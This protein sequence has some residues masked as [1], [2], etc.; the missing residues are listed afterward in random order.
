M[1]TAWC[2]AAGHHAESSMAMGFCFF[3]SAAVAARAAQ[4]CGAQRVLILDWDVHH[5]NGTQVCAQLA[6]APGVVVPSP[7]HHT[8]RISVLLPCAR[9]H[10]WVCLATSSSMGALPSSRHHPWVCLATSSSMGVP[11]HVIIHGC[12]STCSYLAHVIIHGCA[13]RNTHT[14]ALRSW[15][16]LSNVRCQRS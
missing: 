16:P 15:P 10:P 14:L 11:C 3:N 2:A 8:Y 5:G 4:K 6:P 7:T 1:N 9:H 13:F 12:A